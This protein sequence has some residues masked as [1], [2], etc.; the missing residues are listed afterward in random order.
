MNRVGDLTN[1]RIASLYAQVPA[2][3]LEK[4]QAFRT[5]F[6]YFDITIDGV[7]WSYLT[8]GAGDPPLLLLTGALTVP[9]LSW[10]SIVN[11]AARR[12]VIVPAYPPVPTMEA[13]AD[14]IAAIVQHEG[15]EQVHMMGGS[16]GGFVAQVF[17]RRHPELVRSLV[18]SHTQLPYPDTAARLRRP[19]GILRWMPA[20]MVRRLMHRTFQSMMPEHNDETACRIAI[21]NEITKY[22]LSKKDAIAIFER[23]ID[24]SGQLFTPQDLSGWSGK[25]LLAFGE[26]DPAT[27]IEVRQRME[28]LYPGCQVHVF[29]G[30]GHTTAVTQPD[31]YLTVIEGF[32]NLE[33]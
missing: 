22:A 20:G 26:A 4:F 8:G 33:G 12:R 16:Y 29:K 31:E 10:V 11:F 23:M 25:V 30:S 28:S 5:D 17:V 7:P 32:L 2:K 3:Q 21:F 19:I 6:P 13:L 1:P 24:F 18:L 15:V 14:G 9:D 27:P